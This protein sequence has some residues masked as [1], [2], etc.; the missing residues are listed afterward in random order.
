MNSTH[1]PWILFSPIIFSMQ[2]D[3][4]EIIPFEELFGVENK[5]EELEIIEF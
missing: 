5:N 1:P 4:L 3:E 2:D